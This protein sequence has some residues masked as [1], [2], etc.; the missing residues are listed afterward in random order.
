MAIK[1]ISEFPPV[2]NIQLGD[3][4][5]TSWNDGTNWNSAYIKAEDIL[6]AGTKVY[7]AFISQSGAT[8]PTVTAVKDSYMDG[9]FTTDY[10]STGEYTLSGFD[11]LLTPSTV[12]TINENALLYGER[13]VTKVTSTD[14][15]LIKTY[16]NTGALADGIM[17]IDGLFIEIITYI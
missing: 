8:A 12:V 2:D 13:I 4:F 5:L 14:E 1:K 11:N 6:A 7:R 10:V 16:D 17:D 15:V 9:A 3:I